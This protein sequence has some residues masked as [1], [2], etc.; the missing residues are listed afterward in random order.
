[1]KR[2]IALLSV[3]ALMVALTAMPAMAQVNTPVQVNAGNLIAALNNVNVN[4][5]N[6]EVEDVVD[7]NN[8]RVNVNALQ[9][10]LNRNNVNVDIRDVLNDNNVQILNNLVTIQGIEIEGTTLVLKV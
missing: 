3:T 9:N 1:M 6:V 2:I 8:N 10:F 5:T 7:V 4:I